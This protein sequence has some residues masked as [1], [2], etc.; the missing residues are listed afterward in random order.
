MS[1]FTRGQRIMLDRSLEV[2]FVRDIEGTSDSVI[3]FAG[4]TTIAPQQALSTLE[5]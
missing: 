2:T 5:G 4:S 1:G 3:E